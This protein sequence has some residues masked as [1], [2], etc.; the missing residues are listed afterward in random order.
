LVLAPADEHNIYN[1]GAYSIGYVRD[2]KHG[3]GLDVGLGVQATLYTNPSSLNAYYGSS[4]HGGFEIFFRIRPSRMQGMGGMAGVNHDQMT[5]MSGMDA[6]TGAMAS[7]TGIKV[8]TSIIPN[9]P[10]SDGQNV[11]TVTLTDAAGKPVTGAKVESSVAMTSMDMGTKH[12]VF[13]EL[14]KGRY[15]GNVSFSMAG[16]WRVTLKITPANNA[17]PVTQSFDYQVK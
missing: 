17:A 12:P 15:A 7:N 4:R 16:P 14:G 10:T 2:L 5:G 3:S 9:I 11:L 13:K 8:T 1:V 6:N